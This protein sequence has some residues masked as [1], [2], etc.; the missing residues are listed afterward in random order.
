MDMASQLLTFTFTFTKH[1]VAHVPCRRV[2]NGVSVRVA[3]VYACNINTRKNKKNNNGHHTKPK[4][5]TGA[6]VQ[7]ER[8][9]TCS[10]H[11][12][13]AASPLCTESTSI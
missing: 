9:N 6:E 5:A 3:S 8:G 13:I 2:S 12:Y 10:S 4:R 7:N 11:S 1:T